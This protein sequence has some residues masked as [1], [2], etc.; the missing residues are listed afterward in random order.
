MFS[1]DYVCS[2]AQILYARKLLTAVSSD[3]A[4]IILKF[5][6]LNLKK[7]KNATKEKL[8]I[9]NTENSNRSKH[10]G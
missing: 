7:K 5:K 9:S 1:N 6:F 2:R 4:S 8:V 10:S 3:D